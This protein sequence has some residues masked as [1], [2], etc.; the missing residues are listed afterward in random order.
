MFNGARKFALEVE[1]WVTSKIT[2]SYDA[3]MDIRLFSKKGLVC[4]TTRY[5]RAWVFEI[6]EPDKRPIIEDVILQ[7]E[8]YI[9]FYCTIRGSAT[10]K[11]YDVLRSN[12]T[13][14]WDS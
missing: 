14:Y 8:L 10:I 13:L 7:D 12:I 3:G 6:L 1:G 9:A 2:P 5:V 4:S 11:Q